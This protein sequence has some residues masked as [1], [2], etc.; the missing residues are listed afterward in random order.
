MMTENLTPFFAASEFADA[1]TLGGIAVLG[2]MDAGYDNV[3]MAGYGVAGST[4][5]FTLP[6]S[7]VPAHPE[8]LALIVT[9]GP[10]AGHYKVGTALPDGTGLVS[11]HLLTHIS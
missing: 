9:S 7:S 8:G 10:C 11:L 2:I 1:A 3:T 6:A 4:P 5:Q